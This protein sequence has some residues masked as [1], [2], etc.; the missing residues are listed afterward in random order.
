M[1]ESTPRWSENGTKLKSKQITK[2]VL[3]GKSR[4]KWNKIKSSSK[5]KRK[6][7]PTVTLPTVIKFV[8][9]KQLKQLKTQTLRFKTEVS[10]LGARMPHMRS[11]KRFKTG[12]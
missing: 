9:S 11:N 3:E 12:D 1:E 2:S 6:R 7:R 8:L 5:K 10:C 4:K